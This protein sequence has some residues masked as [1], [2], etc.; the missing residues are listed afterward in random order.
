MSTSNGQVVQGAD[1][2]NHLLLIE[3][4]EVVFT[5]VRINQVQHLNQRSTSICTSA[6][7]YCMTPPPPPP[8]HVPTWLPQTYSQCVRI[9]NPSA[10]TVAFSVR[11]G[12]P[13]RYAVVPASTVR[14]PPNAHAL[15]EVRLRLARAPHPKRAGAD[16]AHKDVF[17]V[18]GDHFSQKF[19]GVFYAWGGKAAA[20]PRALSPPTQRVCASLLLFQF[21]LH[22]SFFNF[23]YP[24]RWLTTAQNS[25]TASSERC[26]ALVGVGGRCRVVV[27]VIIVR[28]IL[29]ARARVVVASAS[30]RRRRAHAVA[31]ALVAR[32][33]DRVCACAPR[34]RRGAGATETARAAARD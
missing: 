23:S 26:A 18:H 24:F 13:E 16:V 32:A 4:E 33:R 27:V 7:E 6:F 29:G 21:Q 12:A 31:R 14:L 5:N 10:H 8:P 15:F 28:A 20:L 30:R 9:T 2:H 1:T 17:H 34:A 11:P 22:C 3:P 19:F 25:H